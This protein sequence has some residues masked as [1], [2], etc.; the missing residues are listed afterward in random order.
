MASLNFEPE[1]G[2]LSASQKVQPIG[3]MEQN[4]SDAL[5]E[6]MVWI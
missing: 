1:K 6:N 3:F 2:I 4:A 5:P